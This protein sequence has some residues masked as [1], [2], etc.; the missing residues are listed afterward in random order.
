MTMSFES[1]L[2]VE[3]DTD[4]LRARVASI[5]RLGWRSCFDNFSSPDTDVYYNKENGWDNSV[6]LHY[7]PDGKKTK[8]DV[9]YDIRAAADSTLKPLFDGE[10]WALWV[11][12]FE[13]VI[14]TE[15]K[16]VNYAQE[17]WKTPLWKQF[18]D[19][20]WWIVPFLI[21]MIEG[22]GAAYLRDSLHWLTQAQINKYF[23]PI[24]SGSL[25]LWFVILITS[26]KLE[27]RRKR[28]L[29]N[30]AQAALT[31]AHIVRVD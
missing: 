21:F 10:Y 30:K 22:L 12:D 15:E 5:M 25:V 13:R 9:H 26:V 17:I 7:T 19:I 28:K 23:A 16:T 18:I 3:A 20:F 11:N 6:R 29:E 14:A 4:T 1:H 31:Q 2:L 27:K 24:N 8:V